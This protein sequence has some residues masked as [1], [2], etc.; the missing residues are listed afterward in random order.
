MCAEAAA[1]VRVWE[2]GVIDDGGCVG[3]KGRYVLFSL[4]LPHALQYSRRFCYTLRT[5]LLR[6]LYNGI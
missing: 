4:A 5:K 6:S 1:H 3:A 2:W